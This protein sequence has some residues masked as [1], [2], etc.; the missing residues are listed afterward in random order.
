MSRALREREADAMDIFIDPRRIQTLNDELESIRTLMEKK[1][2]KAPA[3]VLLAD[4]DTIDEYILHGL[5]PNDVSLKYGSYRLDLIETILTYIKTA[6]SSVAYVDPARYHQIHHM[7]TIAT[8]NIQKDDENDDIF[9]ILSEVESI[10]SEINS[11]SM[12]FS[13]KLSLAL[14]AY[15]KKQWSPIISSHRKALRTLGGN[16]IVLGLVEVVGRPIVMLYPIYSVLIKVLVIVQNSQSQSR[17][18]SPTQ[19]IELIKSIIM[20]FIVSKLLE[21]LNAFTGLGYTCL[22]AGAVSLA[23]SSNDDNIRVIA[24]MISGHLSKINQFICAIKNVEDSLMQHVSRLAPA[25]KN[26]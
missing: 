9:V 26:E 13:S 12:L 16:L 3:D 11:K 8:K 21:V 4:V 19:I 5:V 18:I 25:V 1:A 22:V 6:V 15:L 23:I 14:S 2:S 10:V 7:V 20:L 17:T 24:P